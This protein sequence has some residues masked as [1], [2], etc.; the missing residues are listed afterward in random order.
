MMYVQIHNPE[1]KKEYESWSCSTTYEMK[2]TVYV[3]QV[4][5]YSYGD[6]SLANDAVE[7]DSATPR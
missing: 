3:G 7:R 4:N 1:N 6:L 5:N 2:E